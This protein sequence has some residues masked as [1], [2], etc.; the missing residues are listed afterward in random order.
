MNI[1]APTGPHHTAQPKN[2]LTVDLAAALESFKH[3]RRWWIACSGGVDSL[4]LLHAVAALTRTAPGPW[5]ELAVI[6]VNHQLNPRASEWARHVEV[7][8]A[9]LAIPCVIKTVVVERAS[10]LGIEAAARVARY[11]AFESAVQDQELLLQAHHRDDQI[12]TLFLRLL[13][14]SGLAGLTAIPRFRPLA[15]GNLLRPLLNVTRADIEQYARAHQLQWI[16]DDSNTDVR[17]DRNFLRQNILPV[18]ATRWSSYRETLSRVIAQISESQA[19]LD[20]FAAADLSATQAADGSL[21]AKSVANFSARRQRNVLRYWLSRQNLPLPSAA[22]LDEILSIAVAR[23]DTEPCVTWPGAEVRRFHYRLYAMPPLPPL[24]D[25]TWQGPWSPAVPAELPVAMGQVAAT[26]QIGAGLR[27]DREYQI[28]TRREGDR[29]HPASRVHS[30]TLKKLFQE[31]A[32]APWWRDRIPVIVCGEEIAAVGD[33]WICRGYVAPAHETG[34]Q[35]QWRR[36]GA[37]D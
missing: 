8:C 15:R 21:D 18:I 25:H 12:E 31:A 5:P 2:I 20:E 11:A 9:E 34:W 33:L 35:L 24:P 36:P 7:C 13:R 4:V 10:G 30:Q 23:E 26:P 6:H 14:G 37:N 1:T 27:A 29:C 17:F 22:Q 3:P 28:R 32:L 19:L 16:E